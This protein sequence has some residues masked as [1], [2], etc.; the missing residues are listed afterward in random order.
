VGV[1]QRQIE[2]QGISTVSISLFRPFT[3]IVKPPRALWVPFPFG[4]PLGAPN[5][6]QV[7]HR[8]I[9]AAFSLLARSHGPVIE[10][11]VLAPEEEHLDAKHQTVGKKCGAKGCSLDDALF[12]DLDTEADSEPAIE[13]YDKDFEALRAEIFSLQNDHRAYLQVSG[14]RTQLRDASSVPGSIENAALVLHQFAS[15]EAIEVPPYIPDHGAGRQNN[16]VRL[17]ADEIKAFYLEA[18]LG[19]GGED[20]ENANAY[21]N[22]LW[23]ETRA[24]SLIL[25]ARD[26]IIETTDRSKDPNWMTARAMVPRGYGDSGYSM[27]SSNQ[28]QD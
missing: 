12:D 20:A 16:F 21:N 18:R 13:P 7:Q 6:K 25:A 11:F 8:V 26:R 23:Y 10:D 24:G 17:C 3:E 14:G 15:K 27:G 22:W 4:R 9:A 1:I 19:R 28:L 5:N 2:A